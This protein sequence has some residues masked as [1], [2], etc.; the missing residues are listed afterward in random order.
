MVFLRRL[1]LPRPL[2]SGREGLLGERGG[3]WT[4]N[5]RSSCSSNSITHVAVLCC[6]VSAFTIIIIILVGVKLISNAFS[7]IPAIYNFDSL[8]LN[9]V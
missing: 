9:F 1:V 5:N 6:A 2:R 8:Q 3:E 7:E 4:K